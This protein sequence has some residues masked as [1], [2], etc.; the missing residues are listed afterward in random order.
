M[1]LSEI[2]LGCMSLRTE[3]GK[4]DQIVDVAIEVGINFFDT[5]DLYDKGINESLLGEALGN[6]RKDVYVCSKVGNQWRQ[7]GS[8]WDWNPSK[9]YI[10]SAVEKSLQRLKTDYLDLYLLHGGTI[11]DNIDESI[12]A[13]EILKQKGLI[14][15][16]GI[17][18]IRPN[19]I[20]EYIKRSNISAVMMQYSILDRRP[21][22]SCLELLAAHEIGVLVRGALA[23]GMLIDKVAKDYLDYS[24]KEVEAISKKLDEFAPDSLSKIKLV[25]SYPLASSATTSLVLGASS[26]KQ[27][28]DNVEAQNLPERF[29]QEI[30][31]LSKPI[32]YEKHR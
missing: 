31:A 13:F 23:K 12:E 19:V 10:L 6:R 7:D 11:E 8:G 16:Y 5:A 21:E 9:S 28:R 14:R 3:K 4:F 27:L 25:T 18:S 30:S 15:A 1:N 20:R 29:V 24:A 17:S 2:S 22:E 26:E 32:V